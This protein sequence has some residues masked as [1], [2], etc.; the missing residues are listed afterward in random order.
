MKALAL[1]LSLL[2]VLTLSLIVGYEALA[3]AGELC[4]VLPGTQGCVDVG[5][6]CNG[7]P[8][9]CTRTCNFG[10]DD[11]CHCEPLPE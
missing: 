10:K 6:C 8:P 1:R 3:S 4:A 11:D 9:D 7:V 2:S 5:N